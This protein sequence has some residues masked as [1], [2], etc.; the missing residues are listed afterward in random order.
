MK[1]KPAMRTIK[2]M[3][4]RKTGAAIRKQQIKYHTAHCGTTLVAGNQQMALYHMC[5]A[6]RQK[7]VQAVNYKK[8]RAKWRKEQTA[9][10]TEKAKPRPASPLPRIDPALEATAAKARSAARRSVQSFVP[11]PDVWADA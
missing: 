4:R 3:K 10:N 8:K 6:K 7:A 1:A 9:G 11:P 5:V 2:A